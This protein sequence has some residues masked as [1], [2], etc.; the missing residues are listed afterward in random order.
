MT[1]EARGRMNEGALFFDPLLHFE[2]LALLA[3]SNLRDGDS[4]SAFKYADRRCRS[5][6]PD[7]RDFLLRA[8]ASRLSGRSEYAANDLA[9]ALEVDP[10][11][12][13]AN[14][15]ALIWGAMAGRKNAAARLI[16]NLASDGETLKLAIETIRSLGG[17]IA[18]SLRRQA[19]SIVGWIAWE[20][21]GPLQI[22][23]RRDAGDAEWPLNPD[24]NHPLANAS[25]SAADVR[26]DD[27]DSTIKELAILLDGQ[28]IESVTPPLPLRPFR[29]RTQLEWRVD[30]ATVP[31]T[32]VNII[33]PVYEDFEATRAC[34]EALFECAAK[35]QTRIIVV[36]DHSPNKQIRS[37]LDANA[38]K[39]QYEVIENSINIGYAG[40]VNKALENWRQGDVLLVNSD[41]LL[42]PGAIDRLVDAAYSHKNIGTVTPLSNNGE[43]TSFPRPN[44]AN[45]L[46]PIAELTRI[47][48]Q[49]AA[50]NGSGVVD[51]PNGVGFCLYI[52]AACLASVGSLPDL[53]SKGYFEDVEFC[54]TASE[55]GFRNVCATGVFVGHAGT[56]SF[57]AE[58][59]AL[60]VRNRAI[61][62]ARFPDYRR[63]C[64]AFD[65]ADPLRPARAAIEFQSPPA[66]QVI[67][68][69]SPAGQARTIAELRSNGLMS[70]ESDAPL[71]H[72]TSDPV[73]GAVE[74]RGAGPDA[75]QSLAFSLL[76]ASD[77]KALN[78]YL[79]R[80]KIRRI[81][82]LDA[83][84]IPDSLLSEILGL[85]ARIELL[86]ADLQWFLPGSI[87]IE[88]RCRELETRG[89]C[90]HC[91]S[92]AF[93]P[94]PRAGMEERQNRLHAALSRADA[95]R[96][97]DR[98][99]EAFCRRA[100]DEKTVLLG[101]EAPASATASTPAP[102]LALASPF[103]KLAPAL[104]PRVLGVIVPNPSGL[105]DRQILMVARHFAKLR[106]DAKMV[107]LGRCVDDLALMAA[108]N[109]FVAGRVDDEEY[110]RLMVQYEIGALMLPYRTCFFGLLDRLADVAGLSKAYFDWSFGSLSV[111]P[112]DLAMDPL[113]CDEKAA[114][115]IADWRRAALQ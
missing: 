90:A 34:L 88:G 36:D 33:V 100:F 97:T 76:E 44:E 17:R 11:D 45:P 113:I 63:R 50:V 16:A 7:A 77:A 6:A 94:P 99:A 61:I 108:G 58:K 89:P 53:Y 39:R 62:E 43:S 15:S 67:L 103:S 95:I 68:I 47:A 64:A 79:T 14:R 37:Y 2:A 20:G 73:G 87:S 57:R 4:N 70:S 69:C 55:R 46:P 112:G 92:S 56:K 8:E 30:A 29:R 75:P 110:A 81:E 52:T 42:P 40:S 51:L 12:L 24:A 107:V 38:E 98:M 72:C 86:C 80:L 66:R 3:S 10:N 35:I 115:A 9:R 22:R 31:P 93:R 59:R 32:L 84:S 5:L 19:R 54:L 27:D 26:L 28:I 13:L 104:R 91:A 18:H 106:F 74:L 48:E 41:A 71:I 23:V 65:E 21:G 109:V 111:A 114:F 82:I 78:A 105:I 96:P 49:A 101:G 102:P 85:D 1:A 60:V 83:S 25:W